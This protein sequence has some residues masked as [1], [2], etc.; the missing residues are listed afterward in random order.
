MNWF[1]KLQMKSKLI[2]GFSIVSLFTVIIGLVGLV[3]TYHLSKNIYEI[4]GNRLPSVL[5]LE[6]INQAQTAVKTSYRTILID[7]LSA[8]EIATEIKHISDAFERAD[9]AWK[10]YDPLPQT[11]EEEKIWKQFVPAWETWKNSVKEFTQMA[12]QY[13]KSRD[14]TLY[15]DMRKL[16][17]GKTHQLFYDA[18]TLLDKVIQINVEQA[19]IE[20]K[21][22]TAEIRLARIETISAII[23]GLLCSMGLALMITKIIMRQLGGDPSY[24]SEIT[25]TVAD[26]NLTV[27]VETQKNDDSSML[28]SVKNMTDNIREIIHQTIESSNQVAIAADQIANANQ[29]FSQKITEQAAAVEET[30]ATMEEMSASIKSTAENSRQ[31]SSLAKNTK[32]LAE[33]GS[34]V[35]Q[36]TIK[37][38]DEINKSSSKI[39]NISNVIEEIAFQTNLLALNAAVEAARAGEH[40][41][42][43]AVVASEIRNLAGRTTQSA[44]EITTLIEDSSE[45]TGR[46]VMLAQELS[47]KLA[48]IG[49]GIKKVTDL[50]DEV[51]A[52]AQEQSS[53]INQVNTAMGQVDQATQQNASLVEETSAAAEELASQAKGLLDVISYFKVDNPGSVRQ[54]KR[55]GAATGAIEATSSVKQQSAIGHEWTPKKKAAALA[56]GGNGG[57]SE[58]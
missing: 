12:E 40:G 34:V 5:N 23:I 43:F 42:G 57:F 11:P 6:I 21:S 49:G 13:G 33:D 22:S 55:P 56:G 10:V 25:K 31:A 27:N 39:A 30:T 3:S 9:K 19:A 15:A 41:K 4:S 45:K 36:N 54:N 48:E 28:H 32:T 16:S 26:G 37:A 44:K 17:Y 24:V 53:G 18:E 29:S 51:A 20:D 35:M 2:A 46:G 50:M 47:K 1:N 7:G 38:M 14:K 8:E 52:A 58:F